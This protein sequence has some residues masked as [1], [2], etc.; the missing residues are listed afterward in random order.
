M[1][2]AGVGFFIFMA[3]DR[4][5]KKWLLPGLGILCAWKYLGD[6][7]RNKLIKEN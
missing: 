1:T 3:K 4:N 7:E 5:N 2:G 6:T